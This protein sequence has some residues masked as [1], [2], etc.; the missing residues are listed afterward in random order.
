MPKTS[1]LCDPDGKLIIGRR[2]AGAKEK[3]M[4]HRAPGN[5]VLNSGRTP[6]EFSA[7]RRLTRLA[8]GT[9]SPLRLLDRVARQHGQ[10]VTAPFNTVSTCR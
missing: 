10:L 9:L 8:G 6:E 7:A 4:Q 5:T 2:L 1:S 3:L